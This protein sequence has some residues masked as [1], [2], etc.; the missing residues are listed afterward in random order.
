MLKNGNLILSTVKKSLTSG[1]AVCS[2][3]CSMRSLWLATLDKLRYGH[4]RTLTDSSGDS[5]QSAWLLLHKRHPRFFVGYVRL[6]RQC[7]LVPSQPWRRRM[8]HVRV[9]PGAG[10]LFSTVLPSAQVS[11]S[12]HDFASGRWC[13]LTPT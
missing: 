12:S 2:G 7:R 4:L 8:D 5:L 13:R 6:V 11:C 10:F 3:S 9:R 1:K